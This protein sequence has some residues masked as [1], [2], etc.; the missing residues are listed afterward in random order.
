MMNYDEA[1]KALKQNCV[2]EQWLKDNASDEDVNGCDEA[3]EYN[4]A[5]NVFEKEHELL[6]LYQQLAKDLD[7]SID[8]DTTDCDDLPIDFE[9]LYIDTESENVIETF[10]KI[11]EL[12]RELK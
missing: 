8:H 4:E 1:I 2:S 7:L 9:Y 5:V 10:K 6:K 12:E 11:T 3:R